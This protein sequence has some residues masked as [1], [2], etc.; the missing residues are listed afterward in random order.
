VA[1][2]TLT[3][4]G[5]AS[6]Y[7]PLRSSLFNNMDK[8]L[9]TNQSGGD[10]VT[11]D[12]LML[13]TANAASFVLCADTSP[14][15]SCF[16]VPV[17]IDATGVEGVKTILDTEKGWVYRPG[18][19]ARYCNVD[20]AV[21]IGEY[22]A[23]GAV[24][25]SLTGLGLTT[26][27]SYPPH[28]A[29]AIAL[30]AIG[31]AGEISVLLLENS[32]NPYMACR[33]YNDAN[34]AVTAN[35]VNILTFNTEAFD[36]AGMHEGV[37]NPERLTVPADQVGS[38]PWKIIGNIEWSAAPAAAYMAIRV[39]GTTEIARYTGHTTYP[40]VWALSATTQ[41]VAGQYVEL[42]IYT[43]TAALNIMYYDQWSPVFSMARLG[44]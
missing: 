23:F 4:L 32:A 3:D 15:Q 9:L 30:E 17:D 26:D 2:D 24:P 16:V 34:I 37:T 36:P 19:E 5:A 20:G 18:Y 33:V 1:D 13:D 6:L 25:G 44:D 43:T 10:V 38:K 35:V 28:H 21:A 7:D 42:I 29:K 22:L 14:Y 8:V 39:D 12:V 27:T 40:R 41:L 11:G 31:G